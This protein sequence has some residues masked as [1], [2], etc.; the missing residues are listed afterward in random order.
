[1]DVPAVSSDFC[2]RQPCSYPGGEMYERFDHVRLVLQLHDELIYEIREKDL[3]AVSMWLICWWQ[4]RN[5]YISS[6][7]LSYERQSFPRDSFQL[8]I[9][10]SS[11]YLLLPRSLFLFFLSSSSSSPFAFII[12]THFMQHLFVSTLPL[13]LYFFSLICCYPMFLF[14]S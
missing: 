9:V 2:F 1:M 5:A 8:L 3:P 14:P 11:S 4:P 7:F 12:S 6:A 10:Y 13:L